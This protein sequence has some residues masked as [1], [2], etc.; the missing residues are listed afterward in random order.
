MNVLGALDILVAGLGNNDLYNKSRILIC[1]LMK[2]CKYR[3][4]S[5]A[6]QA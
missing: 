2:S 5:G 1:L 4:Y 6:A 3:G